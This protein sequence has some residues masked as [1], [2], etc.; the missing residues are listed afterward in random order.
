MIIYIMDRHHINRKQ[1]FSCPILITAIVMSLSILIPI[2]SPCAD[3][4]DIHQHVKNQIILPGPFAVIDTWMAH[5]RTRSREDAF[6][7][8]S[9]KQHE[10]FDNSARVFMNTLRLTQQAIYNHETYRLLTPITQSMSDSSA[11]IKIQ[12][13]S[14]D[15]IETLGILRV[16]RI[17]NHQWKIDGIT[18]LSAGRPRD[19]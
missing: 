8:L 9:N 10:K 3:S 4:P 12:L 16:L 1:Y 14:R 17:N 11:I 13:R 7:L 19:A 18:V 6:L 15:G 2:R 5:V